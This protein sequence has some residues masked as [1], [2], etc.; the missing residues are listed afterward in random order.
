MSRRNHAR[1]VWSNGFSRLVRVVRASGSDR[2]RYVRERKQH[3]ALGEEAWIEEREV[4]RA[5]D[6]SP[7][8]HHV[9]QD[10]VILLEL[11]D[12]IARR[13]RRRRGGAA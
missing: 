2:V 1:V 12:R 6:P 7:N 10:R 4:S 13:R 8:A 11:L 5:W 9:H 3:D